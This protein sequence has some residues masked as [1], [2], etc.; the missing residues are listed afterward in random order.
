MVIVEQAFGTEITDVV[1]PSDDAL[2]VPSPF[3]RAPS[4]KKEYATLSLLGQEFL[5]VIKNSFGFG[6]PFVIRC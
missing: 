2:I 3:E 6:D 4:M 1:D 5:S